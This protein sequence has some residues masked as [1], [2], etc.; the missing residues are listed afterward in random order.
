MR[1]RQWIED[2]GETPAAFGRQLG[3]KGVHSVY[4][5]MANPRDRHHRLPTPEIMVRIFVATGGRVRPDD[6][7]DLPILRPAAGAASE[8]GPVP[9]EVAA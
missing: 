7:Y 1:L 6:F 8:G 3:L 5:Y 9:A 4:R 2:F